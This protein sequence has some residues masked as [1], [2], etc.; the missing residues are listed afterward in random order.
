VVVIGGDLEARVL[1][2]FD[3]S[4]YRYILIFVKNS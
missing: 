2:V 4:V 1:I 3:S